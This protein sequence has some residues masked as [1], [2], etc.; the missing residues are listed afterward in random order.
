MRFFAWMACAVVLSGLALAA[1]DDRAAEPF[2]AATTDALMWLWADSAIKLSE[3]IDEIDVPANG[4]ADVNILL[5]GLASGEPVRVSC[6]QGGELYRLQAVPVKRNSG[7]FGFIE[8]TA[9]MNPYVQRHAPFEVFDILCPIADGMI[10]DPKTVEAVR[11]IGRGPWTVGTNRVMFTVRQGEAVR[12]LDFRVISHAVTLPS[13]G[14]CSFKYTNWFNFNQIAIRHRV[15]QWSEA[16]W[17][18]I[19]K[20]VRMAAAGRQNMSWFPASFVNDPEDEPKFARLLSIYD[21]SGIWYLESPHLATFNGPWG[22]PNFKVCGTTNVTTSAEGRKILEER[23]RRIAY[24]LDKFSLRERW[25]QHIADEPNEANAEEYRKTAAIVRAQ[26]PG[27][28]LTDAVGMTG[29]EDVIDIPCPTVDQYEKHREGFHRAK[30]EVWTY[31]CCVPGGRWMNRFMDVELLRPTLLPWASVHFGVKGFLH[32]G[33]NQWQ[34]DQ[35]PFLEPY[36]KTWAGSNNGHTLPPGDTHIV[37]PGADG[38]WASARLESTRQ[39]M[40]DAELLLRLKAKDDA[41]AERII[42]RIVYTY[43]H[44]EA[45][46]PAYRQARRELL[47]A[48]EGK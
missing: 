36:P 4:V 35:D 20:Y 3:T 40:E 15:K 37:Y 39:G 33:Y 2:A 31:V 11:W 30:D 42:R 13:V 48:L 21:K 25:R 12:A 27:V 22:S 26:L 47:N 6:A 24:L 9:G 23:C 1:H 29:F 41:A 8:M 10:A 43:W 32:W 7:K 5:N 45:E 17:S 16:H 38:P 46:T 34:Q 18:L 44:F 28:R 19:E 14:R